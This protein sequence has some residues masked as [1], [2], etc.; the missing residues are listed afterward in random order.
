MRS[1]AVISLAVVMVACTSVPAR[2][3]VY[4]P[5]SLSDCPGGAAVPRALPPIVGPAGL[6]AGFEITE[7]ARARDHMAAVECHRTLREVIS[8]ITDFNEQ[9]RR[10]H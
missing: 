5:Q 9:Q 8:I 1:A 4:V 7:I 10:T 6:R 3:T 2:N